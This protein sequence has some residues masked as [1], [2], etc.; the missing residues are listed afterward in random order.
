MSDESL[1]D[2]MEQYEA[3]AEAARTAGEDRDDLAR[4][5]GDGLAEAVQTAV[6]EAGATVETVA[7]SPDGHRFTFEA[8]LDR[9]A[10]VAALTDELPGGFVVSHVNVDGSLSI[11][12]TG[13]GRTPGKRE[14]GALLKAIIAEETESDEDGLITS[15]PTR[16]RVLDR[17]VELGIDR[18]DA[19]ERLERLDT[20]E[21][22]DIADGK[23]Y[24]ETNFSRF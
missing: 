6:I 22:V 5:I 2:R 17:A 10:L 1:A 16:E 15:V 18:D 11:E 8:R 19:A 3:A 7:H 4:D 20:L 14:R 24:P 12:W 9:A 21:V 13:S 23:V